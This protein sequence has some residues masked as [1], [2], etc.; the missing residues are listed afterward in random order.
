MVGTF[1]PTPIT[2]VEGRGAR[3]G[4]QSPMADDL[5]NHVYVMKP[6]QKSER[7]GLR[8]LVGW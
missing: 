5:I 7:T 2:S 3:D 4:V 8:E 6:S 1:S